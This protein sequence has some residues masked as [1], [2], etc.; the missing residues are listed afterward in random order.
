MAKEDISATPYRQ[1][2]EGK[3]IVLVVGAK[4]LGFNWTTMCKF[5]ALTFKNEDNPERQW[6]RLEELREKGGIIMLSDIYSRSVVK[7]LIDPY[8]DKNSR[9]QETGLKRI[10]TKGHGVFWV[11]LEAKTYEDVINED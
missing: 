3:T 6:K 2:N 7:W 8:L 9:L 11:F 10:K 1:R 5:D 4:L